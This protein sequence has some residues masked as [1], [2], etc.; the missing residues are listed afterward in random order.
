VGVERQA[1]ADAPA[2]VVGTGRKRQADRGPAV[3][4]V[5]GDVQLGGGVRRVVHAG[6]HVHELV[7]VGVE[8]DAFDAV[9]EA[10]GRAEAVGDG[11]P[12]HRALVPTV[13]AADIGARVE[14]VGGRRVEDEAGDVAAA[15]VLRTRP[16]G[17]VCHG[18]RSGAGAFAGC[19]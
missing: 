14:D 15:A 4:A 17:A 16:G 10:L 3:A 1:L 8:R 19:V 13:G 7:V 2:I 6:D 11:D 18:R 12:R 5:V 9:L